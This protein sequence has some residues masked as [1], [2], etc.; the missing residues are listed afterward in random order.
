MRRSRRR[1]TTTLLKLIMTQGLKL[2][3]TIKTGKKW[4]AW[5]M[6]HRQ[7]IISQERMA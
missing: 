1:T 5:W 7:E 3:V 4:R 2:E 6:L